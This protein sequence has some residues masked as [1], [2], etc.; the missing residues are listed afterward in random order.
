M[1]SKNRAMTE[2]K[3][4]I[5]ENRNAARDNFIIFLSLMN[6][7]CVKVSWTTLQRWSSTLFRLSFGLAEDLDERASYLPPRLTHTCQWS[8]RELSQCLSSSPQPH[9]GSASTSQLYHTSHLSRPNGF[10]GLSCAQA[11]FVMTLRLV[12]ISVSFGRHLPV[13]QG[14]PT[15]GTVVKTKGSARRQ[16]KTLYGGQAENDNGSLCCIRTKARFVCFITIGSAKWY[17]HLNVTRTG[18]SYLPTPHLGVSF[19]V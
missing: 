19:W 12:P 15:C 17:R 11:L 5:F 2:E 3:T 18:R 14:S 4:E 9:A 10:L 13:C 16:R 1:L 7:A 6:L 8:A